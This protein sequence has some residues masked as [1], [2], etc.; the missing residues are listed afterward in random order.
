MKR[1]RRPQQ[2][3]L[4]YPKHQLLLTL[5]QSCL[6]LQ[7]LIPHDYMPGSLA[8]GEGALVFCGLD[9]SPDAD[10]IGDSRPDSHDQAESHNHC[11]F[12]SFALSAI[13]SSLEISNLYQSSIT[14][15]LSGYDPPFGFLQP[16]YSLPLS[17]APP[18][19]SC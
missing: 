1:T 7:A 8:D 2:T 9:L 19:A 4:R 13:L 15:L 10:D 14:E 3:S 17:R 18:V 12:T 16:R 5:L 6:I 11:V